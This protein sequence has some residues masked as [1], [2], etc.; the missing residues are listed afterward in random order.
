MALLLQWPRSLLWP[1]FD[2]WPRN[3]CMPWTQPGRKTKQSK[4]TK[5]PVSNSWQGKF[6]FLVFLVECVE[7]LLKKRSPGEFLLWL[8]R[9]Q[10][11]IVSMRFDPWPCSVS[12]GS[13]VAVSYS[14]GCR[15]GSDAVML[16]MWCQ[17]A[18]TALIQPL[19]WELPYA[20]GMALKSKK[21]KKKRRIGLLVTLTGNQFASWVYKCVVW[22]A[23]SCSELRQTGGHGGE[24]C[25]CRYS[26]RCSLSSFEWQ[27]WTIADWFQVALFSKPFI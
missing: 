9:L 15:C 17:L 20:V 23:D 1:G 5:R 19:A 18:A 26:R 16:W 22:A 10:T 6:N 4:Q 12:E 24:G 25:F 2:S 21:K 8:S 13:G 27:D 11:R 7:C 14:V 3:F